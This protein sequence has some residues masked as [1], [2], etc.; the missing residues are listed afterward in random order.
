MNKTEEQIKWAR[1]P[2][3]G[4][5]PFVPKLSKNRKGSERITKRAVRFGPKKGKKGFVDQN[6]RIWIRDR[7][8]S[9]YPDHWDVQLD[10]GQDYFKVDNDG[11]K[12]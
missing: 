7:A 8:H 12:L 5:V 9:G 4:A 6:D 1:L 3:G 10:G 2:T 11:N